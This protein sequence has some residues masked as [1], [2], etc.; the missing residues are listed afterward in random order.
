MQ[1]TQVSYISGKSGGS[2]KYVMIMYQNQHSSSR[3]S[4]L[5]ICAVCKVNHPVHDFEGT[6]AFVAHNALAEITVM[7]EKPF[8]K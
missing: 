8:Q 1:D 3:R 6:A 5:I 2:S 4:S 7:N